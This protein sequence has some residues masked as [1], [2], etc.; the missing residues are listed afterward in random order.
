MKK[1]LALTL[2][3]SL[4]LSLAGCGGSS[5]SS[6]APSSPSSSSQAES[7]SPSSA[8][9][10]KV[11]IQVATLKGP[12]GVA[13]LKMMEDQKAGQT[14]N[15][16]TFT[17]AGAPD[18]LTGKIIQGEFDIAALPPNLAAVLYN[19]TK[20]QIQMA[21]VSALGLLYVVETGDTVHSVADLKGRTL[22]SSGK[23]SV[24]EFAL[25]YVLAQNSLTQGTDVT[26]EYK[27]EHTEIASLL[28]A[29]QAD[30]ALLPQPFV[31][32]VLAQND[33]ARVALDLTQEWD[34]VADGKGTLT[35][36]CVVVQKDFAQQHPEAVAAFLQ[37]YEASIAYTAD[38][39]TLPQVGQ[40]AEAADIMKAAVAEKAIPA[41]NLVYQDGQEMKT[42]AQGFFQV[43]FDA[44]PTSVGGKLPDDDFYYQKS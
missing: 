18:E 1:L 10:E 21:A 17:M 8:P 29:G 15:N 14:A 12:A 36:S 23:G 11:D 5:S 9:A 35:M 3:L 2:A 40:W 26:V 25:N 44:D 37:E 34:K 33:K 39:K 28:A 4:V 22:Y 43:L 24:P 41:C 27:T 20:G 7:A 31:T 6:T 32:S 13:M 19:K 16:Y 38:P 42:T 30:L